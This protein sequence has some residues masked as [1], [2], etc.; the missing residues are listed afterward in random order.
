[1]NI[2]IRLCKDN[3]SLFLPCNLSQY[4][5]C[6][7]SETISYQDAH[8]HK[9]RFNDSFS[10]VT[11]KYNYSSILIYWDRFR[12]ERSVRHDNEYIHSCK[13]VNMTK[14]KRIYPCSPPRKK[15][16]YLA[17]ILSVLFV[18]DA[19]SDEGKIDW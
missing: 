14:V 3:S 9:T 4:F 10:I 5:T 19:V 11:I 16:G 1:M 18:S 6:V 7:N 8:I 15:F 13:E 12:R 17:I 2:L